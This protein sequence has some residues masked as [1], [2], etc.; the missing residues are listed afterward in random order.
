MGISELKKSLSQNVK[1]LRVKNHLTQVEL[2]EKLIISESL[3]RSVE[4]PYK[5]RQHSWYTIYKIAKFFGISMDEL[6]HGITNL[7][8][9]N[10]ILYKIRSLPPLERGMIESYILNKNK[11]NM[12]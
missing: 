11:G 1:K 4:L 6:V 8:E 12:L 7:A 9:N 5:D 3:M 2:A 10:Q